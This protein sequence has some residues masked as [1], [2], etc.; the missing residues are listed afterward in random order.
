MVQAEIQWVRNQDAYNVDKAP[1]IELFNNYFK[2][3]ISSILF[4]N[5]RELKALAYSTYGFYVESQKKDDENTFA[6]YVGTQSDKMNDA[7]AAMN[8]LLTKMPESAE[9]FKSAKENIRK[10]IDTEC[11]TQNGI[12]FIYLAAQRKGLNYDARKA[13]F[14]KGNNIS[15]ADMST[16][17]DTELKGKPYTYC[18]VTSDKRVT[19]DDHKNYG[20]QTKPDMKQIY[21]Y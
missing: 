12:I 6:G 4:Q 2:S 17:H 8:E 10:S 15:F 20:E 3:G 14:K 7:I 1:T 9:G 13:T 19:D 5:I 11:I 16:F 18:I 21:G